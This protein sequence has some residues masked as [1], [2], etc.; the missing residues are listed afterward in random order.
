M[1][2]FFLLV[3]S[4]LISILSPF[5]RSTVSPPCTNVVSVVL[6]LVVKFQA[7]PLL[8]ASAALLIASDT[9]LAVTKP[10]APVTEAAPVVALLLIVARVVE[11]S[12]VLPFMAVVM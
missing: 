4:W 10:S 6:E 12:T 7:A 9:F 3:P 1:V 11:I 5:T 8:A 2:T